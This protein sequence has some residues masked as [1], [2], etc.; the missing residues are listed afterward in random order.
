MTSRPIR[1]SLGFMR[2]RT[3]T[4]GALAAASLGIVACATGLIAPIPD[5]DAGTSDA[6]TSDASIKDSG[7]TD[8]AVTCSPACVAPQVCSNGVCKASCD[9]PLVKCAGDGGSCVDTTS[10]KSNCGSCGSPCT[11]G[12]AGSLQPGP[13]NPDAGVFFDGGYDGGTGWALGTPTCTKSACG[14]T[15]P[16]GMTSCSDNLCYDTQNFHDHC[17]NCGTACASG[18]EWCTQGKCCAVGTMNCNG[19]CTDVLTNPASCGGCGK[20]C[21]GQT[22]FCS[23]GVCTGGVTF[24]GA[25]TTN[26]A[27]P[28]CTAWNTFRSSLTGTYSS[29]TISGTNDVIGRTCTGVQANSICQAMRNGTTLSGVVCGSNTWY[30]STC[31]GGIEVGADTGSCSCQAVTGYSARPCLTTNGDWGGVNTK[32]CGAPSQSLTVRCQ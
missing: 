28:N 18:A 10:D 25:F 6:S 27:S 12:D 3:L 16:Q 13:N 26:V 7:N 2:R 17:G 21:S 5:Q 4:V 29:I 15:C 20:T 19:T 32:T 24:T 9:P 22:P 14:V 23:A 30:V 11:S 31:S 1:V 8:A